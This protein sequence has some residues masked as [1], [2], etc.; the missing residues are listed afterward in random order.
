MKYLLLLLLLIKQS[1]ALAA[2][3]CQSAQPS[4]M[5][6][7]AKRDIDLEIE[8]FAGKKPIVERADQTLSGLIKA[9]SPMIS[10]WILKRNLQDQSEDQIAKEWRAYFAKNFI[11]SK[12]PQGDAGIDKE[13][14]AL[15]DQILEKN[16]TP[17]FRA[18]AEKLFERAQAT[19]LNTID[20][21]S[22][23]EKPQAIAR[24]KAIKLYWPRSLKSSRNNSVPLDI[25]DWSVAYD[26]KPNEINIGVQ[27]LNYPNDET[28]MAVF[29]HEMGHAID[30]CRWG[31]FLKKE[32][33]FR[34]VGDC[35]RSEKSVGAKK[36]DDSI[37]AQ[38]TPE[39]NISSELIQ[40]LKQNPTCNKVGYPPVGI[41]ADQLPES[42]ADW[43][44]AEVMSRMKNI[45]AHKLRQ[46]LCE[47][48]T[49]AAGTSYPTNS[50]RLR[51]IYLAHPKLKKPTDGGASPYCEL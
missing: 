20:E 29:A 16:L 31:M 47:D 27:A 30:S 17:S 48:K 51:K 8:K 41:Q 49:L 40:E 1:S 12:Y 38:I 6:K 25:I 26:P 50:E 23:K 35:L 28:F 11:L 9:K 36:R 37:L 21:L 43:F 22:I 33:P 3:F 42:F 4:S 5:S 18:R 19:A 2:E 44:S 15:V 14:E 34:K 45:D 7:S 32:W 46:D 13:V 10:S 24:I 39:H